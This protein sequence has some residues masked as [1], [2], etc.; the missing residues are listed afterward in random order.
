IASRHPAFGAAEEALARIGADLEA[1][2]SFRAPAPVP[3][4]VVET[5]LHSNMDDGTYA[6]AF[7]AIQEYLRAGDLYQANLT[8]RF[9]APCVEPASTLYARLR[10]RARAPY[11]ALF[12][13]PGRAVVSASPEL[14]LAG[15]AQTLVTRPIKGTRPRGGDRAEDAR[16]I[17]ELKA[18]AKDRA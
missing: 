2:G 18:S 11:G 9:D 14:F 3:A 7:E 16:L 12:T 4:A 8:R 13:A 17:E 15:D 6:R 1:A 10:E 5:V